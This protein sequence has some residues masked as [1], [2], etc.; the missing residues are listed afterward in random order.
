MRRMLLALGMIGLVLGSPANAKAGGNW[1]GL[2]RL[3]NR[4]GE[5]VTAKLGYYGAGRAELEPHGPYY[6]WI[7]GDK[8]AW[9][10]PP[11]LGRGAIRLGEV[12]FLG[13]KGW[14]AEVTFVVPDLDPG[15]YILQV[16]NDPCTRT[17]D[18]DAT[19]FNIS[20]N[21]LR[22]QLMDRIDALHRELEMASK[23]ARA[24]KS[25]AADQR[26]ELSTLHTLAARLELLSSRV[27]DLEQPTVHPEEPQGTPAWIPIVGLVAAALAGYAGGRLGGRVPRR[28][29]PP[30]P[31]PEET[32]REDEDLILTRS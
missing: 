23:Q 2:D 14:W 15:K 26:R 13:Q 9:N 4:A 11:P 10:Q 20:L 29:L 27:E 12:R 25:L 31:P 28:R 22:A 32:L 16:C 1:I 17:I 6:L 21:P 8:E 3:Y 30:G 7:T 18:V 24:A 5:T 19:A